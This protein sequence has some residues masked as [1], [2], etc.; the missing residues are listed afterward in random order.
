[1]SAT[2]LQR[3]QVIN[4][5]DQP[6]VPILAADYL[7]TFK[8]I[9]PAC[10]DSCCAGWSCISVDSETFTKCM[11]VSDPELTPMFK[12]NL[13]EQQDHLGNTDRRIKL[14]ADT[15]CPFHDE[16]KLCKVQVKLGE[17]YLSTTC[18]MYP[19]ISNL[20]HGV[21]ERA[22]VLSCPEMARQALLRP[23]GIAF[24][25]LEVPPWRNGYVGQAVAD[26][27]DKREDSLTERLYDVR[28]LAIEILQDRSMPLGRRLLVL[29]QACTQITSAVEL[30]AVPFIQQIA[31]SYRRGNAVTQPFQEPSVELALNAQLT[32]LMEL[33]LGERYH[34]RGSERFKECK[35]EILTGLKLDGKKRSTRKA[36][37]AYKNALTSYYEPFME[38]H[39]YILENYLVNQVFKNVFPSRHYITVFD[40]YASLMLS[41]GLLKTLLVGLSAHHRGLNFEIVIKLVQSFCKSFEHRAS[42]WPEM[43]QE[44][45]ANKRMNGDYM[46]LLVGP[47]Q[48]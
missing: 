6:T 33:L 32:L 45:R 3:L 28:D 27:S 22:A 15:T 43:V 19:R 24:A 35:L 14:N 7:E 10:E 12:E 30:N 42:A 21:M 38:E 13:I 2:G 23:E 41:Y 25:V 44:L 17:E 26:G 34:A 40:A 46:S 29:G 20:V 47:L 37:K 39:E 5:P 8:C 9:G 16:N 18:Q 11:D 31:A 48:S 36:L 1:M 4:E